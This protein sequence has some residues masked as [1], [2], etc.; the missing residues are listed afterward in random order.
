MVLMTPVVF[1]VSV[2]VALPL[3][4]FCGEFSVECEP[5][6]YSIQNHRDN[7]ERKLNHTE[8]VLPFPVCP[9][10]VTHEY[11]PSYSCLV[12][13]N[14]NQ[15]E[16]FQVTFELSTNT[17]STCEFLG[18]NKTLECHSTLQFH[19]TLKKQEF[20]QS[21]FNNLPSCVP[22]FIG[23]CHHIVQDGFAEFYEMWSTFH[24]VAHVIMES[25]SVPETKR[26]SHTVTIQDPFQYKNEQIQ[27]QVRL[28]TCYSGEY[29]HK[30]CVTTDSLHVGTP[31]NWRTFKETIVCIMTVY[32]A[33]LVFMLMLAWVASQ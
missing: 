8:V 29:I 17:P 18:Q 15:V 27:E 19:P 2:F 9:T 16:K 23:R 21:D 11:V 25:K 6:E 13:K 10:Q 20:Q 26:T 22:D 4:A 28:L 30:L 7:F 3:N 5:L 12:F 32:F 24:S 1:I 33:L 14:Q 31:S